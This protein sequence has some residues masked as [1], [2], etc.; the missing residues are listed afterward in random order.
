MPVF[1]AGQARECALNTKTTPISKKI[2]KMWCFMCGVN[3]VTTGLTTPPKSTLANHNISPLLL[4]KG[5][6]QLMA[7]ND[8]SN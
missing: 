5:F 4:Y 6:G 2:R 7:E 8:F 3:S 1:T